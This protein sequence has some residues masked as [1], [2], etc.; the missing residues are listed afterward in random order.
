MRGGNTQ[1]VANAV[2]KLRNLQYLPSK[3]N[4]AS[5]LQAGLRQLLEKP[6]LGDIEVYD[7][8]PGRDGKRCSRREKWK[9]ER[10]LKRIFD[11]NITQHAVLA[12]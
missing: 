5:G 6:R 1:R 4:G 2:N 11:L 9:R 7:S 12:M 8:R 3:H 10:L